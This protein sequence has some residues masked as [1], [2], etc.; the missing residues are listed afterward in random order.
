MVLIK[1]ENIYPSEPTSVETEEY[2]ENEFEDDEYERKHIRELKI[3][4][5]NFDVTK[6]RISLEAPP[7]SVDNKLT[8]TKKTDSVY[9]ILDIKKHKKNRRRRL[10]QAKSL[11][12]TV[13]PKKPRKKV[14]SETNRKVKSCHLCPY[15]IPSRS[16]LYGHY[17]I[18]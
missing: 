9:K 10:H 2:F 18:R 8:L 3:D 14:N 6:L 16:Q 11:E 17:S 5:E 4:V 13:P 15:K 7:A 12:K 1:L